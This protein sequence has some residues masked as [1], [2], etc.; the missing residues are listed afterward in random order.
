MIQTYL[1]CRLSFYDMSGLV[2]DTIAV[3]FWFQLTLAMLCL[4]RSLIEKHFVKL[5][6][7][8]KKMFYLDT[9]ESGWEKARGY[10]GQSFFNVR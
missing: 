5:F 3:K 4:S 9:S 2:L 7:F 8:L 6:S 1:E 10:D